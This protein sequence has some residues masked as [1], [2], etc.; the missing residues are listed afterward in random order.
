MAEE[1]GSNRSNDSHSRNNP[2]SFKTFVKSKQET[3][4]PKTKKKQDKLDSKA[5]ALN[6]RKRDNLKDEAPFPEINKQVDD[7]DRKEEA[8]PFSFKAFLSD[9]LAS[10]NKRVLQIIDDE[11]HEVKTD[12]ENTPINGDENGQLNMLDGNVVT[13]NDSDST[14]SESESGSEDISDAAGQSPVSGSI[15]YFVAPLD[16]SETQAMVIEE[17]NQLKEENEK[18]RRDLQESNQARDEEKKR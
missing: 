16:S 10:R 11:V 1:G 7:G 17:L 12:Q 5:S 9:D 8:N 3:N 6:Q 15:N 2:F 18:L 13:K 14:D 4:S